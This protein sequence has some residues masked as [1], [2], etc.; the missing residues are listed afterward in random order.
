VCQWHLKGVED[1]QGGAVALRRVGTLVK[2]CYL[3][4]DGD[5]AGKLEPRANPEDTDSL[6]GKKKGVHPYGLARP[7]LHL[8]AG[9]LRTWCSNSASAWQEAFPR[10]L[11]SL[12]PTSD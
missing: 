12:L 11:S 5:E 3:V 4:I 1:C 8:G 2:T 6:S 7:S 9:K 10:S